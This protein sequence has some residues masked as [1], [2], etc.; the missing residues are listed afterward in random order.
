MSERDGTAQERIDAIAAEASA[1]IDAAVDSAALEEARVRYLGRK[2][3]LTAI[4]RGVG[5]LPARERGAVGAAANRAR[6]DLEAALEAR[7]EEIDA[8]ELERRLEADAI[9]VTLPGLPPVSPGHLHLLNRTRREIEDIFVGL[10]YRVL[11][12]PEVEH[13][14]YNF[15]AL[16]HPPGHPAR[17]VQDSFY[18][19][20]STLARGVV[21]ERGMPPGPQDVVWR[22]HTSPMQVRAMEGSDPP[23]FIIVPGTV[24][25]RD[26]IDAT[27]LPMFNQVE[28]LAVGEGVSLA[29][30]AGTLDAFAHAMFGP[31]RRTRLKPD[32]FPFT[33]PSVQADVSCFRCGGTGQLDD[34]R[35]DPL[36][37]GTGWI[38]VLGAGMVDPNVYGFVGGAYDPVETQG[39]AFGMGIERIAM[40]KHGIP[41]LRLFF[42][43]DVR[44]L[45]Q[46]A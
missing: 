19:D 39:F 11:E 31:D 3:E 44:F 20:P 25:R 32:F 38:E 27:H 7:R 37:K 12:G 35:R 18:V 34:G 21:N 2:S 24:Y 28:G 8:T 22:T 42:E 9:D 16:N 23:L 17:L 14:Y 36:C 43:N 26:T 13:D 15:T 29:D 10:G 40:L 6:A 45:E 5:D 30:L 4:L 46:F 41:D 33:E 1:A